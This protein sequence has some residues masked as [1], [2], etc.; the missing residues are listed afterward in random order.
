MSGGVD[1]SIALVLLKSQGWQPVGVSLKYSIWQNKA[2]LL[3]ENVCCNKE[4]F[5]IAQ[6]ICKELAVPYHIFDVSKEFK[7]RVIDYFIKEQKQNR[8]P[9]PC[10]IC[11]RY[12]KFKKLFQWAGEHKIRFVATGHYARIGRQNSKY[13]LL[14][15]KD[16]NK[17]QTYNLCLLPQKWLRYIVFPLG[18]YTK[19]QVYKKAEEL[20]FEVFLK[21]RQSQD[22]CFV[23]GKCLDCFLSQEI[24]EQQ[25]EIKNIKGRTLGKHQ[26]LHFYT[27]GQRKGINL[28][29]GPYYVVDKIAEDNTLIVSKDR[30]DLL[31]K[32]VVL[33]PISFVSGEVL[34]KK[35]K[36]EA[37]IRSRHTPARAILIPQSPKKLWLVFDEPQP[38]I[39][40][41]QFAVFYKNKACLGGGRILTRE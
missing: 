12:L 2:N 26:G 37:K 13:Q 28:T 15:A 21:R 7:D 36:I 18:D 27:I 23:A 20:G 16:Q 5:N 1:S 4:S 32:K 22:F 39:T 17:D 40:P 29:G 31:S 3:R 34:T 38:N 6:K 24:G 30:R 33:S 8:T 25:G 10:I 19:K 35:M 41:G 14:K 11:N 9:N